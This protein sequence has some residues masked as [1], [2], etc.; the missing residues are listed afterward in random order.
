VSKE[1]SETTFKNSVPGR[2][3]NAEEDQGKK[4]KRT[5]LSR[6]L[7]GGR[8][9]KGVENSSEMGVVRKKGKPQE[10]EGA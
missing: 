9:V 5:R 3:G 2:G 1:E 4:S 6:A 8:N 10:R 7:W